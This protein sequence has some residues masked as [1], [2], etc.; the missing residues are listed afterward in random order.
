MPATRTPPSDTPR[1]VDAA[2]RA[3][4]R[5]L[6][7]ELQRQAVHARLFGTPPQPPALGRF[8]LLRRVGA[9]GMGVVYE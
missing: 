7:L 8:A 2:A 6:D 4:D 9:G 1:D 5:D 3:A